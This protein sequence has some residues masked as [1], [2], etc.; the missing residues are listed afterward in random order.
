MYQL[1]KFNINTVIYKNNI[2]ENIIKKLNNKS[3]I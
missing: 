3:K 1:L 2:K